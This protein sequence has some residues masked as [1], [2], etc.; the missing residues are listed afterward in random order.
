ML[1]L[2]TATLNA[3][4][5][6][7]R[8]MA[9]A[10]AQRRPIEHLIIDG[11]SSDATVELSR[12][13]PGTEVL[14]V[15]GCSI[16]EAWNLGLAR[17]RG[18]VV[19]FLNADDELASDAS[20]TIEK[21]FQDHANAEI[22]AGCATLVGATHPANAPLLLRAVPSGALNVADLAVGVPAINAMAFRRT[23]FDRYG[24]FET[25]YR[26]AGD[27]AFLLRLALLSS[28]PVV[29]RID[30]VLYRYYAHA[31]SLTL[32]P[33]LE[34]RLRI[35]H[36][37]IELS[38]A[39]LGQEVPGSAALWL[40]HM[41]QREAAVATLRCLAAGRPAIAFEFARGFFPRG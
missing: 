23:V 5:F 35:A 1:T 28:P 8:A 2:I 17:A 39:L 9:S 41:R 37:H 19:M 21:G 24:V 15:P 10:A 33:S 12:S 6:L 40:R 29:A 36:D 3:A 4:R 11:G 26:V 34:Q 31:G 25:Q 18:D 14:V 32:Q 30:S 38:R 13:Q 16:Y 22:L 20:D 27:R 7:G